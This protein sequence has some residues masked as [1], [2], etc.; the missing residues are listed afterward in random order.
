[1]AEVVSMEDIEAQ[2]KIFGID[3][4]SVDLDSITLPPGEDFGIKRYFWILVNQTLTSWL[5]HI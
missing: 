4:S 2:A 3:L 5:I 1:M